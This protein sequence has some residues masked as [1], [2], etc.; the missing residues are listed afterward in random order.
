MVGINCRMS[1]SRTSFHIFL[2]HRHSL[3][4]LCLKP[5]Q[6]MW[7]SNP[8]GA[9]GGGGMV[10]SR[11]MARRCRPARRCTA[12][13]K[14][15]WWARQAKQAA[16]A[17]CTPASSLCFS[18]PA[19]GSASPSALWTC[20]EQVVLMIAS[21][22]PCNYLGGQWPPCKGWSMIDTMLAYKLQ[23]QSAWALRSGRNSVTSNDKALFKHEYEPPHV[24]G[25]SQMWLRML[26]FNV[27]DK[28]DS[29]WRKLTAQRHVLSFLRNMLA[30]AASD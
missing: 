22:D 12:M 6:R 8:P 24:F 1:D 29:Q 7:L 15:G 21:M 27:Q 16:A 11:E 10:L 18:Q 30:Q 9:L 26:P 14:A 2:E 28:S 20:P 17:H 3:C 5:D 4:N 25:I 23:S 19:S 13:Q